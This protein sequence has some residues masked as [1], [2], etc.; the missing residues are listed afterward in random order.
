MD[1]KGKS[2]VIEDVPGLIPG[3]SEGKGL[4]IQFLKHVERTRTLLHL[5]DL[6]EEDKIVQNYLDIRKELELFSEDLAKKEEIIV[7]SK[8]DLYDS[9]MVEEIQRTLE[10]A[11]G[12][13][14]MFIISAASYQGIDEL[15]DY[16]IKYYSIEK[17]VETEEEKEMKVYDLK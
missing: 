3:A 7:L 16:L 4:G 13:K 6:S 9:E 2:L 14:K 1:H 15:K 11:I 12:K 10:E 17:K 8:A 5:L